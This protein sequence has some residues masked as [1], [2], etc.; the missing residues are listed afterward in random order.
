M[1]S[2]VDVG[3]VVGGNSSDMSA[4]AAWSRAQVAVAT[5]AAAIVE[6]GLF[7][8][9]SAATDINTL[10]ALASVTPSRVCLSH[11]TALL[12]AATVLAT[13]AGRSTSTLDA[14]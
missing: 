5:A 6:V 3:V 7:P 12:H 10:S 2:R 11:V 8:F 14:C 1:L 4:K 9:F 13:F